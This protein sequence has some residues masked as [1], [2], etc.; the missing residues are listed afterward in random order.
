MAAAGMGVLGAGGSR[1]GQRR[2]RGSAR[3]GAPP[4]PV[5]SSRH[6][7]TELA[8][9]SRRSAGPRGRRHAPAG[10]RPCVPEA[11]AWLPSTPEPSPGPR[12]GPRRAAGLQTPGPSAARGSD[13]CSPRPQRLCR[14]PP[15]APETAEGRAPPRAGRGS[16]PAPAPSRELWSTE[17]GDPGSGGGAEGGCSVQSAMADF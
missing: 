1:P 4:R 6:R 5:R 2:G 9:A 13:I 14:P 10:A 15:G 7:R 8:R 3:E 17:A 11:A 16:E 12:A